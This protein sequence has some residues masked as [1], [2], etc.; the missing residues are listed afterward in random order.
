MR[1]VLLGIFSFLAL[2]VIGTVGYA[3]SGTQILSQQKVTPFGRVTG[4]TKGTLV[5]FK[6]TS[7]GIQMATTHRLSQYRNT[8]WTVSRSASV[9]QANGRSQRYVYVTSTNAKRHTTGWV[10]KRDLKTPSKVNL[11]APYISQNKVKAWMGC[12][13]ASLLEGLH[14]KG[15]MRSTGLV[16]FMKKLPRS[17]TNNPNTGFAGSPYK[18]TPGVFQSIFPKPLAKWGNRYHSVKNI[19]GAKVSKLRSELRMNHPVVVYVTLHFA[20]AHYGHYFWGTG[21]NNSHVMLLDGYKNGAY[22]VADPNQGKYWVSAKKFTRSYN[23]KH[24]AVTIQ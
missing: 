9:R 19:S 10:L 12:E 4:T 21:I 24:Y 2:L 23:Y 14:Y 3:S 18:V 11:N 5:A 1:K 13:S 20:K 6:K 16:A 7:S 15:A 17:K 22:H 8:A